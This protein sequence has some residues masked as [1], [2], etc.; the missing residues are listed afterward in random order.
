MMAA[1]FLIVASL[2]ARADTSCYSYGS[3]TFFDD[4]IV[5]YCSYAAGQTCFECI[6]LEAG[7][8]CADA[9]ICDPNRKFLNGKVK[10]A[11]LSPAQLTGRT[12]VAAARRGQPSPS[13]RPVLSRPASMR[14]A[15]LIGGSL[16]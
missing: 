9:T 2:P 8:G 14:V 10:L 4:D 3:S 5:D 16:L 6:D 1:L 12:Q 7:N 11:Q 13:G 15:R